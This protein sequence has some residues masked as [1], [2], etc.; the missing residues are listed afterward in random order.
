MK[1]VEVFIK[2]EACATVLD[3]IDQINHG[4]IGYYDTWYRKIGTEQTRK[5]SSET[6][7]HGFTLK[8][9]LELIIEDNLVEEVINAICKAGSTGSSCDGKIFVYPVETAIKI[10]DH[11]KDDFNL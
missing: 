8:V 2:S 5:H 11:T 9:K 10:Q 3:R 4:S 1:K 7:S 6:N